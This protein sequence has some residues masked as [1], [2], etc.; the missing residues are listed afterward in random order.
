MMEQHPSVTMDSGAAAP[1]AAPP[2][3]TKHSG[4]ASRWLNFFFFCA[5][6]APWFTRASKPFWMT[7]S[8]WCFTG[9]LRAG[10]N[11]N[12]K[13]LLGHDSDAAARKQLED[14]VIEQFYLFIYDIG[15][16]S[17]MT[18]EQILAQVDHVQGH[19]HFEAARAMQ[20][21]AILATAHMGSFEV[22]IAA[23]RDLEPRLHV[24]FQ[25]DPFEAFDTIRHRLHERLDVQEA[26]VEGGWPVWMQLR[27][28]LEAD[29]VA[30]MQADRVMPGQHGMPVPFCGG[31]IDLPLGPIKLAALTGAPIVPVFAPRLPNGRVKLII[32]PA[33]T[34]A[35][36]H[37]TP[38]GRTPPPP[39]LQIAEVLEK[40][41][42]A[43][44]EQWLMLHR[45]WREDRPVTD[46]APDQPHQGKQ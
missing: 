11:A 15:R 25:R 21:G 29:E 18:R 43:R 38:R 41:V 39:L 26:R 19:E 34:V 2:Q 10:I 36:E 6:H 9:P 33:I 20:R 23:A 16:A 37:A 44:P 31:H 40:H 42:R 30:L 5:R 7:M 28:A 12:A 22:G 46:T 32:E 14:R 35:P 4:S 13:W 3:P 1:P 8:R 27:N 24:V 17:A 45:M